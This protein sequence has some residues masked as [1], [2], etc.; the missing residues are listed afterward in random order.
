MPAFE[1]AYRVRITCAKCSEKFLSLPLVTI[2]CGIERKRLGFH[3]SA[4]CRRFW[5]PRA[6]SG[7]VRAG[8]NNRVA[9]GI[10]QPDFPVVWAAVAVGRIAMT[11][12]NDL[13]LQF[14]G[15]SKGCVEVADFKPQQ[16]AVSGGKLW[17]ADRTVMMLHLPRVQLK[18]Q[19]SLRNETLIVRAA[20]VTLATQ[21][22]LIPAAAC[23]DITHAN[24]GLWLHGICW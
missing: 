9:V 6:V 24:Q 17:V 13:R 20:V 11:W 2:Q 21:E 22:P 1:A 16:H 19:P 10:T 5:F 8:E 15:A 14:C 3:Q 4:V 23:F 18:H 12:Q 7:P